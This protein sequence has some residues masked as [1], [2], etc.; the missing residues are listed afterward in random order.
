MQGFWSLRLQEIIVSDEIY[1]QFATLAWHAYL[2]KEK[3]IFIDNNEDTIFD[4]DI[5]AAM[6]RLEVIFY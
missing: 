5:D 2:L 1:S 3:E 4:N 6:E